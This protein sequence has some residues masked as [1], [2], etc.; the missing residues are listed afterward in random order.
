MAHYHAVVWLD[1]RE[2]KI[3]HFNAEE[4]GELRLMPDKPHVHLHHHRGSSMSDFTLR[5]AKDLMRK[6]MELGNFD[7][8][9]DHREKDG[10]NLEAAY[11]IRDFVRDRT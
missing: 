11:E 6:L 2:A 7:E 1:H 8:F 4:V 10:L 5:D 9:Q 3:F